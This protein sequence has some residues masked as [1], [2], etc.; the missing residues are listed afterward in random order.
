[1][2]RV[3]QNDIA[4]SLLFTDEKSGEY[5]RVEITHSGHAGVTGSGELLN[6]FA[7]QSPHLRNLLGDSL[8]KGRSVHMRI[9]DVQGDVRF[10]VSSLMGAGEP[11][12]SRQ[13]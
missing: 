7:D 2:K 9:S 6:Y 5:V 8:P 1:M 12:S 13:R 11:A 10:A 4:E 3:L